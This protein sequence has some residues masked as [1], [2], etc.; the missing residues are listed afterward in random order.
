MKNFH[1]LNTIF[2]ETLDICKFIE[3]LYQNKKNENNNELVKE[4]MTIIEDIQI[5]I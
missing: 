4:I 5:N 2:N 1:S 3:P